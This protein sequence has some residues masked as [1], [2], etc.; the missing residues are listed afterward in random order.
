MQDIEFYRNEKLNLDCAISG[1]RSNTGI[2]LFKNS[3]IPNIIEIGSQVILD[4]VDS[5]I[6]VGFLMELRLENSCVK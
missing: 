6:R 3:R 2:L 1:G 4:R 5:Q